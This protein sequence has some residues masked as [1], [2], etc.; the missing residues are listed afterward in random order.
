MK[1][2]LLRHGKSLSQREARVAA[3]ADR[4]LSDEGRDEIRNA[5]RGM[6]R[7]GCEF[8][9]ILTSPLLRAVQTSQ[10]VQEVVGDPPLAEREGLASGMTPDKLLAELR[11]CGPD[12]C[13]LVVGHQ[14]DLGEALAYLVWGLERATTSLK[15]GSLVEIEIEDAPGEGEAKIRGLLPAKVLARVGEA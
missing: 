13:V 2:Y 6:Q 15:E 1:L 9:V 11:E 5:A 7:L 10:I 8:D 3:D 14:P 4:P 12:S